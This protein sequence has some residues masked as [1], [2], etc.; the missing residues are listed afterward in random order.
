[1]IELYANWNKMNISMDMED[2]PSSVL[3]YIF[4][5]IIDHADIPISPIHSDSL[6]AW[7]VER[8]KD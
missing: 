6:E 4:R 8:E 3:M 1:M 5:H 2:I 7:M